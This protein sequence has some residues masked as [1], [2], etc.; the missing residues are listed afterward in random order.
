MKVIECPLVI[1]FACA[2]STVARIIYSKGNYG[3]RAHA[4]CVARY[5]I[6]FARVRLD[7]GRRAAILWRR[8]SGTTAFNHRYQEDPQ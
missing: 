2:A 8:R 4:L 3:A 6:W 5:I 7:S 1:E